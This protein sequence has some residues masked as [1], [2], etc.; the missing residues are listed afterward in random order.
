[1]LIYE[2]HGTV[3]VAEHD[4]FLFVYNSPIRMSRRK[5]RKQIAQ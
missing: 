1:M 4:K 3:G 2:G 5:T